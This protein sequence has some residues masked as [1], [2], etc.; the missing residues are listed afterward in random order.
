MLFLGI[1]TSC[2]ETAAAVV[3]NGVAVKSSII[4]ST[5]DVF[6]R[7][8]G[9][10][11][12]DAARRQV[13]CILPVLHAA[14]CEAH[15]TPNELDAIAVTR[16]PGLLGS[17]LVGV[18]AAR[19][20]ARLWNKPLIGVHHTFGHLSS[21]WPDAPESPS[22]PCVTLSVSGGHSDLWYRT[23]HTKGMLLGS[24]RDDAAG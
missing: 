2:D 14:T 9:V 7:T 8:G 11:P 13:E 17:L 22:F 3:E 24:T 23:S 5:K 6:A 16:G 12:E 19:T 21:V 15:V 20:V 4:T 10:V 18:T 1:E